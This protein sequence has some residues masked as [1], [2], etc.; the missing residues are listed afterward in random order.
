M[1]AIIGRANLR[2]VVEKERQAYPACP[3]EKAPSNDQTT[4]SIVISSVPSG[5]M[6]I[7]IRY[8][9]GIMK[10]AIIGLSLW[11][12]FG[13][14]VPRVQLGTPAQQSFPPSVHQTRSYETCPPCSFVD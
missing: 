2:V 14:G 5:R 11:L 13:F 9:C 4:G 1:A 10:E 8:P 3:S 12:R 7:L 6:R